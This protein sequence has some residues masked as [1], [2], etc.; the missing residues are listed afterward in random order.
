ME[1]NQLEQIRDASTAGAEYYSQLFT[2]PA[3]LVD[4]FK[5]S[6]DAP[7]TSYDFN[8]PRTQVPLGLAI[9]TFLTSEVNYDEPT[10][11]LP[12]VKIIPPN[13]ELEFS[14]VL[15]LADAI[16]DLTAGEELSGYV[17]K[18]LAR[19]IDYVINR[20]M[21]ISKLG[22]I[23]LPPLR[24]QRPRPLTDSELRVLVALRRAF[25]YGAYYQQYCGFA[26]S[27]E[28][29]IALE[30]FGSRAIAIRTG[31]IRLNNVEVRVK[32]MDWLRWLRDRNM[33]VFLT[34]QV[35]DFTD[36]EKAGILVS[37]SALAYGGRSFYSIPTV[38]TPPERRFYPS[39]K[40]E[41]TIMGHRYAP[42]G[43]DDVA[44]LMNAV[45]M[46]TWIDQIV[47]NVG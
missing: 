2:S 36:P 14:K 15:N 8:P 1:E 26:R 27:V 32:T 13:S 25:Y 10:D 7:F 46:R 12:Y 40:R 5:V 21:E 9:G 45:F 33:Y 6:V 28:V 16:A 31:W 19:M 41:I 34:N 44:R 30:A 47:V 22:I 3:K 11:P 39:P 42:Y 20:K 38:Q 17:C 43:K 24:G 35:G 23:S 4:A 18:M 37:I 29:D